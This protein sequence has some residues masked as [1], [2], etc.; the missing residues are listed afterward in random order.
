MKRRCCSPRSPRRSPAWR[1]SAA[2]SSVHTAPLRRARPPRNGNLL[3]RLSV[4]RRRRCAWQ[5]E[6]AAA[7]ATHAHVSPVMSDEV[8]ACACRLA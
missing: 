7:S 1:P 8:A 5:R 2:S 4:W 6:Q 3:R